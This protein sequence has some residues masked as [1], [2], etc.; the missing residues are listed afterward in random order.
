MECHDVIQR[1]L[2]NLSVEQDD[3]YGDL[4]LKFL[5]SDT[6]KVEPAPLREQIN[7]NRVAG[8]KRLIDDYFKEGAEYKRKIERRYRM[9]RNLFEK[10]AQ[11]LQAHREQR[12]LVPS[13]SRNA[14]TC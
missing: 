7:R 4:V 2:D 1:H 12:K 14:H 5:F 9:S 13:R 6:P 10:I 8:D 11:D 3:E